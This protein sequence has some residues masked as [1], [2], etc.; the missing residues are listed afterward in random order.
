[1]KIALTM[2]V[3]DEA[4]IVGAMLEHHLR[5]GV[6]TFIITDNASVDG[7]LQIIED[8]ATR[9][10]VD[11]RHDPE[12]RKQQH[13]RVTEMARDAY[14]IYGA[15]W[16]I[17]ADADEFWM[18][19]D[20][21]KTL[22]DVLEQIPVEL[23]A[24]P[25]PVWNM[26]GGPAQSGSGISRLIYR[27]RRPV[28]VLNDLGLLAH[29]TDN[30]VHIGQPTVDVAQ[31]NHFVDIESKGTPDPDLAIEVLH[32]PWRSWEQFAN[33]VRNAGAGYENNMILQPSPNHH[34]MRDYR[35]LKAG[36]L[37]PSYLLRHP[38][39]K[40]LRHGL[41]QGWFERDE[42]LMNEG[43]TPSIPDV[44]FDEAE[45]KA[46]RKL[47]D[48]LQPLEERA[49]RAEVER[50]RLARR[51]EVA[52]D[53]RDSFDRQL[54]AQLNRRVVKIADAAARWCSSPRSAK[55]PE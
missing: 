37:T 50:D 40:Q 28:E 15:D 17:N 4:D 36:T 47:G 31:G 19:V 16:V 34:G 21:R 39:P 30:V 25:V 23:Q 44:L 43:L 5:Q 46:Q 7:T 26:V 9:A 20:R 2:M 35:R 3:R 29:A 41:T 12:H 14:T 10:Q 27:D 33:K 32:L 51:L 38:S 13:Q 24:F 45:L 22:R 52:E 49:L 8:F 11:L 6:N 42:T 48:I 54:Q 1:M 53:T 18:P 55:A